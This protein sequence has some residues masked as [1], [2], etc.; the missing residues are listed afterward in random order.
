M[1]YIKPEGQLFLQAKKAV[2]CSESDFTHFSV[3]IFLFT[4]FLINMKP[5]MNKYLV[6]KLFAHQNLLSGKFLLFLPL[7]PLSPNVSL[8]STYI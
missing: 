6:R 4:H 2:I 8:P 3:V 1:H 7:K 5:P